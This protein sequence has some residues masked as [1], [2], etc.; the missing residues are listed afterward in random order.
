MVC[1]LSHIALATCNKVLAVHEKQCLVAD[2][3]FCTTK[4]LN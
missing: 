4:P 3:L 2:Y 1:G